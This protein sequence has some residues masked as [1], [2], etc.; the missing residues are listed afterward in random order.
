METSAQFSDVHAPERA[1]AYLVQSDP[2]GSGYAD[3]MGMG[4]AQALTDDLAKLWGDIDATKLWVTR[5]TAA[6]PRSGAGDR[7]RPRR[8]HRPRPSS[9][10]AALR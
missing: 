8:L 2:M 10:F 7:P 6:L 9:P 1:D 5:T 3:S 4:A